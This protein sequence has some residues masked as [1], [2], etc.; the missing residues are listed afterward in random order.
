MVDEGR[1][2][3]LAMTGKHEMENMSISAMLSDKLWGT[4]WKSR[5]SSG[6]HA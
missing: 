6:Y 1:K 2:V 4:E 5:F 3:G